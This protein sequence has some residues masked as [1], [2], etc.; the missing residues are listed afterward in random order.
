MPL[1]SNRLFHHERHAVQV[2][3]ISRLRRFVAGLLCGSFPLVLTDSAAAALSVQ[4]VSGAG[5]VAC[6][7]NADCDGDE[8]TGNLLLANQ[9]IGGCLVDLAVSLSKPA[10]GIGDLPPLQ[11]GEQAL[12]QPGSAAN[13]VAVSI[14]LVGSTAFGASARQRLAN[15]DTADS[16][17][18]RFQSSLDPVHSLPATGFLTG[19]PA[20]LLLPIA[21]DGRPTPSV[22]PAQPQESSPPPEA[23]PLEPGPTLA[24]LSGQL[25]PIPLPAAGLLL[26]TSLIGLLGLTGARGVDPAA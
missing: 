12:A 15:A 25:T 2:N 11:A 13:P 26:V 5:A 6:A 23:L 18:A 20:P 19:R 14:D 17:P 21:D 9:P 16:G 8:E 7:D 24:G 10:R 4:V 22:R 3:S 1:R